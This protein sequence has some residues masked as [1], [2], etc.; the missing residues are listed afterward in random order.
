[1]ALTGLAAKK[2][3]KLVTKRRQLEQN[4]EH[5][6]QEMYKRNKEL[7]ET[8]QTLSLL[9]QIDEL[10]LG[11]AQKD[12]HVAQDIASLLVDTA[13]FN[14]A[15]IYVANKEKTVLNIQG[16]A[17]RANS[18]PALK[19]VDDFLNKV[20][21]HPHHNNVLVQAI[22][23]GKLH[24]AGSFTSV[25]STIDQVQSQH[26]K[27]LLGVNTLFMCPLKASTGTL[28]LLLLALP[29]DKEEVSS[30]QI[31]LADRLG[32]TVS[33]AI[34]NSLLY[35]EIQEAT[36]RLQ[37]QNRKLKE[38]DATKDEFISMASH[39][40]RTP[41]TT[42]KGY[43]SMILDGDVGKI[44]V[45]EKDLVQ[46]A[47][48]S[49][50]RMVYLI[51]DLLNVSRLQTGKF[52]IDNKPTDLAKVLEGEIIQLKEQ[53]ATR[54]IMLAYDKPKEFPILNLDETKIRQVIMNFLD[55]GLY[56][57]PAEGE[58]TAKLEATPET[59]SFTVT[60]TGVG[61]P[62]NLQHHLF[63]KFYRADNARKMRPDGTGLGLYMAKKVIVA[64]GGA[65]IFKSTEGKGSTFGFSFP[66]KAMEVKA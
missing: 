55:N 15:V 12:T 28:G 4:L 52:V 39:Q 63:T 27:S 43:L 65:I 33:I 35:E 54:K 10:V 29:Q 26:L 31:N 60:D 11:A 40:L 58:V 57:T 23:S 51:A 20:S 53:A 42:I 49:A 41:L 17:V 9:R 22:K 32:S 36:A 8:N 62:A 18:A 6:T 66:R 2:S 47:F 34:E 30:F 24:L 56:Y 13:D 14:L 19:S 16:K 1:M 3:S 25:H 7:T 59:V 48:D 46:H 45:E 64:Q 61:V 5:I 38:L 50:E 21:L 44:K 37:V